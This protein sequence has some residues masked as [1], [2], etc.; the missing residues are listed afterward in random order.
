MAIIWCMQ[1]AKHALQIIKWMMFGDLFRTNKRHRESQ[2]FAHTHCMS[3][4]VHLIFGIGQPVRAAP[5]PGY[6]YTCFCFQLTCI[7]IDI[8]ANHA[9][10]PIAGGRMR[11][12]TSRM[13]CR[14]RCKLCLFQED[15][16][17]PPFMGKM[18]SKAAAHHPAPNNH[19]LGTVWQGGFKTCFCRFRVIHN[20]YVPM[21]FS[22]L[23]RSIV[24]MY[25]RQS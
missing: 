6:R 20:Q 2:R 3:K 12:L 17:A 4:P 18:V 1:R 24:H 9:P 22:T 14:A 19:N 8:I 25:H 16:I 7:E 15:N 23:D 11:N 13:P 21:K 5:M 10:Q